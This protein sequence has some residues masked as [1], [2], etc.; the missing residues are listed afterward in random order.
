MRKISILIIILFIPF[1]AMGQRATRKAKS[2]N[3]EVK[4][5]DERTERM[6]AATQDVFFID[7]MVVDKDAFLD[8]YMLSRESGKLCKYNDLFGNTDG[9]ANSYAHVN[10]IGNKCYYSMEDDNAGVKL[11]TSDLLNNEWTRPAILEGI[12]GNGGIEEMNFPFMMADGVTLYFAATGNESIGGY[13]IFATRLNSEDGTFLEP[14]N[15]G[16]PFNSEANDYMYAIDEIDSI[17]WFVTD[18]NQPEGKVCIYLFVPSETRQTFSPD[19]YSREEIEAFARI[20]RIAD[21]WRSKEEREEALQR[22]ATVRQGDMH[23]TATMNF[24][25]N[26]NTVYESVK[27]FRSKEA[28]TRYDQLC[29]MTSRLNALGAALDKARNYYAKATAQE[30]QELRVEILKSEKEYESL[31]M[32]IRQT[33]KDIRNIENKLLTNGSL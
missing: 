25:I 29:S 27:S 1:C 8:K 7:S 11:Y 4:K 16:M 14:E 3:K 12:D 20:T 2:T 6:I 22:L 32:Q 33:E 18:R 23:R 24:V 17:G 28:R 10:E 5:V 21:T 30:R 26:N 9:Q 31:E 13:D 15:I 19:I